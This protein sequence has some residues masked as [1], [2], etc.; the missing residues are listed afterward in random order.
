MYHKVSIVALRTRLSRPLKCH[1][2][3]EWFV[4]VR[5]SVQLSGDACC[6]KFS[7]ERL[8]RW[9]LLLRRR[10]GASNARHARVHRQVSG[11]ALDLGLEHWCAGTAAAVIY[12]GL[13]S[14]C[15][16]YSVATKHARVNPMHA[17]RI[18]FQGGNPSAGMRGFF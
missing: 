14:W 12:P 6:G 11:D 2:C 5:V 15:G 9:T 1:M 10:I 3:C 18:P 17:V 16:Q 8:D 7:A 4:F 13:H